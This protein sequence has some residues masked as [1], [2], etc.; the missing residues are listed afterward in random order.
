MEV[1]F[2][3]VYITA[4]LHTP[5]KDQKILKPQGAFLLKVF[6]Q[7]RG[8]SQPYSPF[9]EIAFGRVQA[10]LKRGGKANKC[11]ARE[12][13]EEDFFLYQNLGTLQDTWIFPP[14]RKCPLKWINKESALDE[15]CRCCRKF[16]AWKNSIFKVLW[17]QQS[18]PRLLYCQPNSCNSTWLVKLSKPSP[19]LLLSNDFQPTTPH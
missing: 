15:T 1:F 14:W 2:V 6:L 12:D 13:I 10:A 5:N 7:K 17:I 11:A 18:I 16:R 4:H 9:R 3:I 8:L 19:F